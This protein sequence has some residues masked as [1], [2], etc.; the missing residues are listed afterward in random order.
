LPSP[1][2]NDLKRLLI[3]Y[4]RLDIVYF[5][6]DIVYFRLDIVYFRLDIEPAHNDFAKAE[7]GM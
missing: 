5:R 7:Q 6:L 2:E 4:F 3:V 1:A